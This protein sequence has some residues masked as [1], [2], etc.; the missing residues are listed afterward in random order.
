[1]RLPNFHFYHIKAKQK[2]RNMQ[3]VATVD[4]RQATGRCGEHDTPSIWQLF[5]LTPVA[6]SLTPVF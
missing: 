5:D 6:C 2:Q 1:M 4:W 3:I